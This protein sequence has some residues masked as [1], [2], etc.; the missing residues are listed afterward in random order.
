MDVMAVTEPKVTR[1]AWERLDP[2][3]LREILVSMDKMAPKEIVALQAKME[4]ELKV[5]LLLG[6]GKSAYGISW[7]TEKTTV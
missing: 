4:M 5:Q 6:T 1:A 3:D 7:M 2:R